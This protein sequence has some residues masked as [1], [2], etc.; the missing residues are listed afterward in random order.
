M[1]RNRRERG[2][3]SA[4]DAFLRWRRGE[5]GEG[6]QVARGATR[7]REVGEGPGST[8][9]RWATPRQGREGVADGWPPCY[10]AC[11]AAECQSLMRGILNTVLAAAVELV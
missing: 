11:S 2:A 4:A 8:D 6:G 1:E 3:G 5:A 7:W 10:S 9:M